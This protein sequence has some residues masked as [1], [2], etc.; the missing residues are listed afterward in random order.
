MRFRTSRRL[1]G[2]GEAE[3]TGAALGRGEAA[4]LVAGATG[5]VAGGTAPTAWSDGFTEGEGPVAAGAG[6]MAAAAGLVTVPE[7]PGVDDEPGL[8][9]GDIVAAGSGAVCRTLSVSSLFELP[10]CA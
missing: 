6:L 1:Y 9:E 8:G 7:G 3:T 10:L 5:L 4:G 2:F